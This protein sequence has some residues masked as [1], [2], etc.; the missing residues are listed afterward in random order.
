ME[1][2]FHKPDYSGF[3]KFRIGRV[4][5]APKHGNELSGAVKGGEFLYQ[6]TKYQLLQ[7]NS[8]A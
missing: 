7:K 4:T 3:V 8:P 2:I 1:D 5:D 6:L